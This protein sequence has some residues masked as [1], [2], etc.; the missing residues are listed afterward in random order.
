MNITYSVIQES[1]VACIKD[2]VNDLMSYQKSVAS[3][4]PEFFDGMS[5]DTRVPPA[6]RSARLNHIAIAKDDESVVGYAYSTIA[7]KSIYSGGFAT[8]QCN[9]FFDF[10]SV[11]GKEVGSLSQFYIKDDY[12][13]SGIGSKLYEISMDWLNSFE[14]IKDIF[15]FVS[16]G[17]EN[18][19]RFYLN[20]GF[21]ESHTILE[22][23]ITVLRNK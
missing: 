15:I 6:L 14:F 20:K 1:E 10:N 18:A 4:H 22:G 5:F 11:E 2:L 19:M 23:F 3:I 17:N 13:N 16:N 7:N 9:A 8:L 12:R 21:M